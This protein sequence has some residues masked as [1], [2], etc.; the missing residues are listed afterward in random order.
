VNDVLV[1]VITQTSA[2][3]LV[4]HLGL[5]LAATPAASDLVGVGQP[6]LP[7]VAGPRDDVL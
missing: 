2:Q 6:E 1:V 3:L 7:S 4:V 5:V